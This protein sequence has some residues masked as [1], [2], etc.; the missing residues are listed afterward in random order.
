MTL[1]ELRREL[2][3]ICMDAGGVKP[4][5]DSQGI[6]FSYV[7]A[8]V[9]GDKTPGHKILKAMGLRKAFTDKKTTVMKFE[10]I[11]N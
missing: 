8:V 6:A 4:W 11:T 7:A 2:H 1:N 10:D 5:A 9:R 3:N